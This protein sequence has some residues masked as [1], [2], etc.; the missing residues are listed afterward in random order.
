MQS[1]S[2]PRPRFLSDRLAQATTSEPYTTHVPIEHGA[3][4]HQITSH[5]NSYSPRT[6]GYNA[7]I[8][9]DDSFRTFALGPGAVSGG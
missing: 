2:F 9:I 1:T 4:N 7:R 8:R 3:P 6:R 5:G